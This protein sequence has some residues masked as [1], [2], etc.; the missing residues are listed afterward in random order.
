[1]L[2]LQVLLSTVV[3]VSTSAINS[4]GSIISRQALVEWLSDYSVQFEQCHRI[5]TYNDEVATGDLWPPRSSTG[6]ATVVGPQQ[7]VSF[8]LCP[9][10]ECGQC[11]H[12]F[13]E[14]LVDLETYLD[15]TVEHY[16]GL[17]EAKCQIC[18]DSCPLPVL[19]EKQ[20][21]EHDH[22]VVDCDTCVDQCREI[23]NMEENGYID[24]T[25]FLQCQ[26]I[27]DPEDDALEQLYAGPTCA[28]Q[29]TQI[30]IAVFTDEECLFRDWSKSLNDY[31]K[32]NDGYELRLSHALLKQ[33]YSDGNCIRCSQTL[34]DDQSMDSAVTVTPAC[35]DLY[36]R[37]AKCETPHGMN[38]GMLTN[39]TIFS[40]Q[41]E[42]EQTVCEFLKVIQ[43]GAY[44]DAPLSWLSS[45]DS[46]NNM[47]ARSN[48]TE[49][50]PT[51][52]QL[53]GTDGR[54]LGDY[55]RDHGGWWES[56]NTQQPPHE[57]WMNDYA[58]QFQG[59][60]HFYQWNPQAWEHEDVRLATR[61][62]AHYG[63]CPNNRTSSCSSD[64]MCGQ[65]TV[66][67]HTFLRYYHPYYA[68]DSNNDNQ[69]V[70]SV[71]P[72][73]LECIWLHRAGSGGENLYVG[74]YCS[75]GGSS[76]QLGLFTDN[77]CT[78]VASE[79]LN[80]EK[81]PNELQNYSDLFFGGPN[82]S[83]L[84]GNDCLPCVSNNGTSSNAA[85]A[86]GTV[87]SSICDNL[88]PL[89]GKCEEMMTVAETEPVFQ[90]DNSACSYIEFTKEIFL[91]FTPASESSLLNRTATATTKSLI[92][93]NEALTWEANKTMTVTNTTVIAASDSSTL[94]S[95]KS[96]DEILGPSQPA[97]VSSSDTKPLSVPFGLLCLVL[98]TKR[99]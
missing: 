21:P 59:C 45:S 50:E 90:P 38:H 47:D 78:I 71:P 27:F 91:S 62:L 37:A 61:R 97:E 72:A 89:S 4:S 83:S 31:I 88:Y 1:M 65:Y 75:D 42:Q 52:K 12:G 54:Y 98:L 6:D 3:I 82:Q 44:V 69:Q 51:K 14:Y 23:E 55:S 53:D 35:E 87:T 13:G 80:K 43:A 36:D 76:V 56:S 32:D 10:D 22:L 77:S 68:Q 40:N 79:L 70:S 25:Q 74:P 58:L 49:Q 46:N 34:H 67:L 60:Q 29:G 93:G 41:L 63:V 33:V 15:V 7:F 5:R 48:N 11:Q 28:G 57:P 19:Q 8:R 85:A 26:L 17:Q 20:D 84:V 66:D 39:P 81:L 99:Q 95:D 64:M 94:A 16:Q 18:Y 92:A 30:N 96:S 24:A 73:F 86:G 9:H 2:S